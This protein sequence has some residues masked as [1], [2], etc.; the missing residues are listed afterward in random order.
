MTTDVYIAR[1]L[2]QGQYTHQGHEFCILPDHSVNIYYIIGGFFCHCLKL[3]KNKKRNKT[4]WYYTHKFRAK[5]L[6]CPAGQHIIYCP[7]GQYT[8]LL[9][10]HVIYLGQ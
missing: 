2:G 5:T 6:H 1:G 7:T 9:P 8:V 10:S 3:V 4:K